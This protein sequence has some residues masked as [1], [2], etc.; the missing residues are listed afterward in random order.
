VYYNQDVRFPTGAG[1]AGVNMSFWTPDLPAGCFNV[2]AWW[3]SEVG[4]APDAPYTINFKPGG[5]YWV[6]PIG[7]LITDM[8]LANA[9]LGRITIDVDQ[10]N[11]FFAGDWNHLGTFEFEN[12]TTGNVTLTDDVVNPADVVAADAVRFVD[13]SSF[14]NEGKAYVFDG[15]RT[16]LSYMYGETIG[17]NPNDW[18][19]STVGSAGE[20]RDQVVDLLN[21]AVIGAPGANRAYVW[22]EAAFPLL[23]VDL[24]EVDEDYP[25]P[26]EFTNGVS[27]V[28][29]TFGILGADDGWDWEQGTYGTLND[30]GAQAACGWVADPG[31]GNTP[32][33]ADPAIRVKIGGAGLS[34][35]GTTEG[36]GGNN[37]ESA[38]WGIEINIPDKFYQLL[39]T[40]GYKAYLSFEYAAID[41]VGTGE[42]EEEVMVYARFDTT[43]LGTDLGGDS[44]PEVKYYAQ[45]FYNTED[46]SFN[47]FENDVTALIIG[48]GQHYIDFGVAINSWS[49]GGEGVE[50]YFDNVMFEFRKPS[51]FDVILNGTD[52]SDF[53][54]VVAGA[55]DVNGDGNDRDVIVG[56]PGTTNGNA[57]VFYNPSSLPA[58][59]IL[60]VTDLDMD[61][62]LSGS[63]PGDLFGWSVA[64]AGDINNDNFDDLLIGAPGF[65]GAAGTDSGAVYVYQ[66]NDTMPMDLTSSDASNLKEGETA[67]DMFGYSV[68]SYD[69][70]NAD[71]Y[72]DLFVSAPD[73]G[74]SDTGK[75]YVIGRLAPKLT[76]T[77]PT[78]AETISG[79]I[80]VSASVIDTNNDID[81]NGVSF[82]YS[83]DQVNWILIDTA[84]TPTSGQTYEVTWDTTALY[85]GATYYIKANV[86]DLELNYAQD[87][88]AAFTVDNM[89]P[90]TIQFVHPQMDQVVNGTVVINASALDSIQ[91][92]LGGG[93]NNTK[94]MEFFYSAD[95]V[96]WHLIGADTVPDGSSIYEL[97][98]DTS[99]LTDGEYW[100]R[101]NVTDLDDTSV[102]DIIKVYIDNPTIEPT[103]DLIYPD[104]TVTE[105]AG[106]LT[107]NATAYDRDN[108][109]NASGVSFYYSGD[110]STWIFI[111][112]DPQP[113]STLLYETAWDTTTVPDGM[114]SVKAMV[115]DNT[116]LSNTSISEEFLVHNSQLNR[117]QVTVIK[118]SLGEE[119]KLNAYLEAEAYDVDGNINS[120]G[121]NFY[122]SSDKINWI[123]IDNK[124]IPTTPGGNN[125]GAIWDTTIVDDGRYWLNASVTDMTNLT[126]WDISDEFFVHNTQLNPPIVDVIYPNG[127]EV[128]IGTETLSASIGDLEDNIDDNGVNFYYSQDKLTWTLID[129]VNFSPESGPIFTLHTVLLDWDTTDVDD[130][131]YWLRV[132]ASDTHNLEG[133]DISD[134]PFYIH[135]NETNAP[136]IRVVYPNGGE[137][138]K[139]TVTVQIFG[140][141]MEDNINTDGV[142]IFYSPDQ[143]NWT[144]VGSVPAV[145]D[146]VNHL[147]EL[148]WN[149]TTVPDGVY[150][151]R[152]YATDLT[153]ME[154]SDI[155]DDSFIIHN[156]LDNPPTITI[157]SPS[158]GSTA[159]GTVT[160]QVQVDDLEDNVEVI[161]FYYSKNNEDWEL[162][163][164]STSP[165]EVGGNI[166]TM[167]WN[168]NDLYDGEYFIRVVAKDNNSA[169]TE[170]FT[171]GFNVD[172]DRLKPE[173]DEPEDLMAKF[174][175]IWLLIIIII[176][177]LCMMLVI[178][179]RQRKKDEAGPQLEDAPSPE[180]ARAILHE[181]GAGAEAEPPAQITPIPAGA[182]RPKM[183]KVKAVPQTLVTGFEG[184]RASKVGDDIQLKLNEWR[185]EG[186]YVSRIEHLLET[187]SDS[188]F[189]EFAMF[190][191]NVVKLRELKLRFGALDTLGFENED[192]SIREK[193]NNPDLADIAEKEIIELEVKIEKQADLQ[194]LETEAPDDEGLLPPEAG[195][196]AGMLPDEEETEPEEE[197]LTALL[198]E[199]PVV[200]EDVEEPAPE[201]EEEAVDEELE[202]A[203]DEFDDE[204]EAADEEFEEEL[205]TDE[206][207]EGETDDEG[208]DEETD[209]E[210]FL[211]DSVE[212]GEPETED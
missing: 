36:N 60:N 13:A 195:E 131:E 182:P 109:I 146:P 199:E 20:L 162:I 87:M 183:R 39:F 129:N 206:K 124:A 196:D 96:T 22:K 145:T 120:D 30:A 75:I 119:V 11:G 48:G 25:L 62:N 92:V 10:T 51:K 130:G 175:W 84:L 164:T 31:A 137:V 189:L 210:E 154:G 102:E 4:N 93:I 53:G 64:C 12:G 100:L 180:E 135:N 33:D 42:T 202:A 207:D 69:D 70:I 116:S 63:A 167:S 155:S 121:V 117:P 17:E 76:I 79:S 8:D 174:W 153:S 125:F 170:A 66:A 205:G 122:Y 91:D 47:Y 147:Y 85:D 126:G 198:P 190:K 203:E 114:Y 94:G 71:S 35:Q 21:D 45:N 37:F 43:Y 165:T 27:N 140:F 149:T 192:R 139:G 172:N 113:D 194:K 187:D 159:Q 197:D 127:G 9:T 107:I 28:S 73:F 150:W 16:D 78:G 160:V 49:T 86:T 32:L 58:G 14:Y 133:E 55:G 82:Y 118:P 2:Y 132:T 123:F 112:N 26:I 134:G 54:F 105:A 111:D 156:N 168:T 50:A 95:G 59:T 89:Y 3:Q 158:P 209:L 181:I 67:M 211:P 61:I 90:P 99:D 41:P 193:I 1:G 24:S 5:Y 80:T 98:W 148:E 56:A 151:M 44:R 101:V 212:D 77:Y 188:L 173:D 161:E 143:G 83:T 103:L 81:P 29:N 34:G 179:S 115:T 163:G 15:T 68:T 97:N 38:A 65:D 74:A 152:A 57:Y 138:L 7:G 40:A 6:P 108:D 177:L 178:W 171:G 201:A 110:G 104:D 52:A 46:T 142:E 136:I 23:Y 169:P 19:G 208:E 144:K 141:D 184:D 185:L 157:I 176:I 72:T 88:T 18:Y 128:L 166:Y 106:M 191:A 204:L 200:D 186:F